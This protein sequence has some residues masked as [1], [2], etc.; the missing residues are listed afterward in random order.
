MNEQLQNTIN[1]LLEKALATLDSSVDFLQAELPDVTQQLF[2]WEM[3]FAIFWVILS[4]IIVFVLFKLIQSIH[5]GDGD[6]HWCREC[7]CI[8]EWG[9][10]ILIL[11]SIGCVVFSVSVVTN[12][13]EALKIYIAP[14]LWLMEYAAELIK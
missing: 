2:M 6:D 12:S 9:T 11:S 14:K 3:T 13:L 10:F 4:T 7:G 8:N 1:I 5:K